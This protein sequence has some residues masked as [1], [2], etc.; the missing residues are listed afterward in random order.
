MSPW[1]TRQPP[2]I[3]SVATKNWLFSSSSGVRIAEVRASAML[4]F[5][6]SGSSGDKVAYKVNGETVTFTYRIIHPDGAVRRLPHARLLEQAH[7]AALDATISKQLAAIMH[8]PDF[9]KLEGSW[10][11]LHYLVKNSETGTSL[12]LRLLQAS[13][14]E[15]SRD[16]QRATE[17]DQSQLFKKLYENLRGMNVHKS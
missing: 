4:Y 17:F 3:S 13:K 7:M 1:K 5:A 9:Q 8:H 11:G 10:R 16:L 14:R 15:L 6:W 2:N 12:R